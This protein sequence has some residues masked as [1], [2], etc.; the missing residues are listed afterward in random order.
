MLRSQLAASSYISRYGERTAYHYIADFKF[1][2]YM[3]KDMLLGHRLLITSENI[4]LHVNTI[5]IP[6]KQFYRRLC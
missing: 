5:H 2:I 1:E 4:H 3:Y 6:G